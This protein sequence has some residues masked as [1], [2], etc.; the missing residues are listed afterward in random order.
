MSPDIT[1]EATVGTVKFPCNNSAADNTATLIVSNEFKP[2]LFALALL[3]DKNLK[4]TVE[5]VP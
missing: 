1:F 3:T 5:V 2:A 4:I